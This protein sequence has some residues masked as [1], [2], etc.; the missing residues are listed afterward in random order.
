MAE[1]GREEGR[2][3]VRL[4]RDVMGKRVRGEKGNEGGRREM[5]EKREERDDKGERQEMERG[6]RDGEMK[7]NKG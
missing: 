7:N 3:D 6:G 5:G 4:E 1:K 2:A